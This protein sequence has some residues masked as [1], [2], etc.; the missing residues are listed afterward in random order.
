MLYMSVRVQVDL[1]RALHRATAERW[2]VSTVRQLTRVKW[3]KRAIDDEWGDL[4]NRVQKLTSRRLDRS[5]NNRTSGSTVSD[6][7]KTRCFN[8]PRLSG[9]IV[10][11]L[12]DYVYRL[13][14]KTTH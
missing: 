12:S 4:Y 2:R 1:Q 10:Q 14:F 7:R 9:V 6:R 8:R 5:I 13:V 11:K 3:L